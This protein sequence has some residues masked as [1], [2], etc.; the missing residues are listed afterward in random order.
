MAGTRILP[1][2]PV[3]FDKVHAVS[4]EFDDVV[5]Q[6]VEA[7]LAVFGLANR[8]VSESNVHAF[9][10]D[11]DSEFA[12]EIALGAMIR[13]SPERRLDR[14]DFCGGVQC[15]D[16]LIYERVVSSLHGER[17]LRVYPALG[18]DF[19]LRRRPSVEFADPRNAAVRQNP[20]FELAPVRTV[21]P[22]YET[23]DPAGFWP[24]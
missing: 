4:D 12:A 2:R 11:P 15:G 1:R 3:G 19:A 5:R 16:A 18:K 8:L 22:G 13:Q 21:V 17:L 20:D 6:P 9:K 24:A 7:C 10:N 23:V 14:P